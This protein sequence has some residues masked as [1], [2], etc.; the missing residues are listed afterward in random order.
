MGK[1][2]T[3]AFVALV[4]LLSRGALADT[5]GSGSNTF[6]IEF[7]SVGNLGNPADTTGDPNPVGFVYY[8]YR[9]GKYEISEGII[10]KANALGALGITHDN[11]GPNKPASSISWWEAAKF[12]NWLNTSTGGMPAYKFDANGV[13]QLWQSGDPGY[14]PYNAYRNRLAHY[15]L[16]TVHEFYKAAFFDPVA[17]TYYDYPTGTNSTPDGIDSMTDSQFDLVF[18]EGPF[19]GPRNVDDVGLLSPYGTAGQGGNVWEWLE[20]ARFGE[21]DSADKLRGVRNGAYHN[22][23]SYVSAAHYGWNEPWKEHVDVGLRVV[24]VVP[25][26]TSLLMI[27]TAA[28]RFCFRRSPP[29]GNDHLLT[30]TNPARGV[31]Q[32]PRLQY[33]DSEIAL[34]VIECFAN[35]YLSPVLSLHDGFLTLAPLEDELREAMIHFYMKR[36]GLRPQTP[37]RSYEVLQSAKNGKINRIFIFPMQKNNTSVAY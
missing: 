29:S 11:R 3:P 16:P 35:K 4:L 14:D 22:V 24:F 34:D 26:P 23:V 30:L 1:K 21:N 6:D 9:I 33:L 36:I 20:N 13:F 18:A 15:V 10:N 27:A 2:L 7:V 37:K 17:N 5:F 25:E 31:P 28:L 12:V 19:T 32:G 8:P